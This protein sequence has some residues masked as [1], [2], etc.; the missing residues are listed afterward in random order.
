MQQKISSLFAFLDGVDESTKSG[1]M[2]SHY[3]D[4]V[5][6]V[7]VL[8]GEKDKFGRFVNRFNENGIFFIPFLIVFNISPF[9]K[10]KRKKCE[11]KKNI[12]GKSG[13]G[14]GGI[15]RGTG[16]AALVWQLEQINREGGSVSDSL[17]G[18]TGKLSSVTS[19]VAS[20]LN[21]NNGKKSKV[22]HDMID[23]DNSRNYVDSLPG[24]GGGVGGG[25]GI[26]GDHVEED[27]DTSIVS[28]AQ[29]LQ[30]VKKQIFSFKIQLEEKCYQIRV[31]NKSLIQSKKL[32]ENILREKYCI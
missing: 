27:E 11:N 17:T 3:Q 23:D 22:N 28:I 18:I 19:T 9:C 7:A 1:P 32:H 4:I 14:G 16:A 2:V 26:G 20:G 30:D 5:P 15:R 12:D 31:L 10:K 29:I 24:I 8:H 6:S 13:E 21:N 25:M